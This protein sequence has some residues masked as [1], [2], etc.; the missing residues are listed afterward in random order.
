LF[1]PAA[2]CEY[3]KDLDP[4]LKEQRARERWFTTYHH[5]QAFLQTHSPSH[6]IL[7]SA[8]SARTLCIGLRR[9]SASLQYAWQA[10]K[11]GIDA[12]SQKHVTKSS[13]QHPCVAAFYLSS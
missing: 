2:D 7:F 3:L 5:S 8:K 11:Y 9:S 10:L 4:L 1:G 12:F 13:T 6:L